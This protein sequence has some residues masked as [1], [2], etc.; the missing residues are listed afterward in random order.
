L[1]TCGP[2]ARTNIAKIDSDTLFIVFITLSLQFVH[3]LR[4]FLPRSRMDALAVEKA[5]NSMLRSAAWSG[6][7]LLQ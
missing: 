2:V 1:E 3:R 5:I 4:Q 6:A 7:W